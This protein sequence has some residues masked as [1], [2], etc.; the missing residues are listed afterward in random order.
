MI[1]FKEFLRMKSFFVFVENEFNFISAIPTSLFNFIIYLFDKVVFTVISCMCH[2]FFMR[3]PLV[4]G[5]PYVSN[6]VLARCE[7]VGIHIR[8]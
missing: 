1:S 7:G 5:V 6:S 4:D 2:K 3:K 8:S